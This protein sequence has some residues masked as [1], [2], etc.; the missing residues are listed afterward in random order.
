MSLARNFS[1]AIPLLGAMLCLHGVAHSAPAKGKDAEAVQKPAAVYCKRC[2]Q[3]YADEKTLL[4]NRCPH[5]FA[6]KGNH[7]L[8]EGE[9]SEKYICENCGQTY[10]SLK[11]LTRNT[12][13]HGNGAAH[14]PYRG[15]IRAQYTCRWCGNKYTD[16]RNMTR[17]SCQKHPDG[18]GNHRPSGN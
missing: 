18:H 4:R 12:C 2:G 17:N 1:I 11:D 6:G 9:E 10:T 5:S 14:V 15:G 16:L 7:V 8:F 3:K 13:P